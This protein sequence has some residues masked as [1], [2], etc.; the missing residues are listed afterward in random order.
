MSDCLFT[1]FFLSLDIVFSTAHSAKGLEF[2]TVEIEDDF[3]E[4]AHSD[5]EPGDFL[6]GKIVQATRYFKSKKLFSLL[7][8]RCAVDERN[9]LYVAVTR[10]THYVIM[11]TAVMEVLQ[12]AR[13]YP[14]LHCMPSSV[15]KSSDSVSILSPDLGFE[16][17][18]TAIHLATV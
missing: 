17:G 9:L 11:S 18:H 6:P 13:E 5:P 2:H 3:L 1:V 12:L 4:E 7:T 14:V 10:A 8:E 16:S 15:A